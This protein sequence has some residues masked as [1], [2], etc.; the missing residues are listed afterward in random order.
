MRGMRN[1]IV[2]SLMALAAGVMVFAAR[3]EVYDIGKAM[4]ESGFWK[5]DPVIFVQRRM[6]NRFRFTSSAREAAVS[7]GLGNVAWN[8]LEL[9]ETR[10]YFAEAG[11][12]ISHVEMSVYNRGDSAGR[13]EG[14]A[15]RE[16]FSGK[17]RAIRDGLTEE[18]AKPPKAETVHLKSRNHEQRVQQWKTNGE[19]VRST[20]TWNYYQEGK[21]R[22]TFK[23]EFI[24]LTVEGPQRTAAKSAGGESGRKQAMQGQAAIAENVTKG[25][26][27]DV[28]IDN[29]P[30]VDQ[31]QK[32]YCAVA[33]AER[34]LR[35]YGLEIDEHEL[36]QAAGSS[37]SEGTSI[38]A[39]KDSVEAIGRKYK[40]ATV[41]AYGDFDK[42]VEERIDGIVKEVEAYN[43][44]AKKMRKPEIGRDT[45]VKRQGVMTMY[46]PQ[47][48][49]DAMDAEV[50]KEMKTTGSQKS[51]YRKFMA[52]VR[53]QVQKGIPLYWSVELGIYPEPEIPQA[54]GGHMR[55]IIGYNDK[56]REILYTD[57]WGAGH[58]LKRMP[59]DWA[60]TI[61]RC[62]MYMKPLK[63]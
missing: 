34:V 24:R 6:E 8:G 60:W 17:L 2:K 29:V 49:H 13:A 44:A 47:A 3:G 31:G 59:A 5:T 39:M 57:S 51:R 61:S 1:G 14:E 4:A 22:R 37:A 21:N 40:L 53:Q 32:G 58:E 42:A 45:Y 18:G 9:Y 33:T 36:A 38:K 16:E 54:R 27:G 10:V 20:L 7:M 19:G 35:Y 15:A 28:Y 46:D 63:K 50:R 55:M 43:K 23:P 56:K 12:G 41:V 62:M 26:K 11:D 30:M 48:A 25:G 52:D